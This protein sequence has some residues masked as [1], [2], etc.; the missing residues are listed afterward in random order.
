MAIVTQTDKRSGIIY[1]YETTYYWDKEK[2]QSRS[3]RTCI[4][5]VDPA[6]GDIIP[7]RGRAKKG[8]SKTIKSVPAKTGPK[9]FTASKRLYYGA[10]YLLET[11]ADD[12]GLTNDLKTCFPDIYKKLLS[13]AFYLILE[14]NNPLYRF[15]KW[16]LTHK[17]PYGQDIASPR[18][19]ELFSMISDDQVSRFLRL[20]AKRRVEDEY[21]A[22]DS[23]SISSYSETLN[24]V[25]WGRNKENDRLPQINLLL[26]FGEKSGLPFYYRKLAGN[27]PDSKTVKHLLEDLDILGFGRTK[28]VMD[29]GFYS[30]DN[31]NGLYREH[32]KFLVGARLSL[33]LIRKNLDDVYD[34]IRMFTNYDEGISTY[35]YTVSAEW[36]YTQE[37][38]YKGDVI[39][40]KRRIYIHYYYSIEKGADDEQAFDKRISS[41]CNELLEGRPVE[42]HKKAYAQFFEVKDTPARGRQVCYKEDEIKAARRYL[43][44]FAL[45]TNE[46]MDAFTALH[47]YRMKD[48]VEK[49]FGNIKE[50]LNMRRLL[51]KSEKCLDGKIFTEFIALI[52]ISHLDHRMKETDLYKSY[53]MQQLLDKLDVLECFEDENRKLRI[54][55]LLEKQAKIYETLGVALPTSSC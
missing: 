9:P 40:D 28:F 46:K 14:D 30:E 29:R 26:V 48:V 36:D 34:D 50:R 11:F 6:T 45:I 33:K 18:S 51:S 52:L 19:S 43:G 20:Q 35:G 27:I 23:S 53:T 47:L 17:H 32:V 4:G 15:E 41:L 54:G 8:G 16:N 3:K 1:A 39:K 31:I 37:R 42:E 13:V 25:Q 12:T 21:W 2:Q 49:A 55:E 10:T 38:P 24:Q 22:Y 5:K 44:Y 7:T